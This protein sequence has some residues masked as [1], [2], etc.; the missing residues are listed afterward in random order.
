MGVEWNT[1]YYSVE[2][3]K[4]RVGKKRGDREKERGKPL[5]MMRKI[6]GM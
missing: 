5:R 1:E 3:C 6:L 4:K 2:A